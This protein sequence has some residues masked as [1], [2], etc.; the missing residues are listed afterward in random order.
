M[1]QLKYLC[2]EVWNVGDAASVSVRK[3]HTSNAG[4]PVLDACLDSAV[5]HLERFNVVV[6]LEQFHAE[7]IRMLETRL[8]PMC[9]WPRRPHVDVHRN[10]GIL[11]TSEVLQAMQA[12]M[13][14]E[15]RQHVDRFM[16]YEQ[17]LY[18]RAV[19]MNRQQLAEFVG[20]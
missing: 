4:T 11:P 9:G 3:L 2:A 20:R 13:S 10:S 19:E 17:R 5:A 1:G 15:D 18:Q 14:A 16:H 8:S 6:I 12:H 7:S